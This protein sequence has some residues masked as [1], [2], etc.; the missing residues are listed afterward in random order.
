MMAS[1]H[2]FVPV[3]QDVQPVILILHILQG[4][5]ARAITDGVERITARNL[6]KS[7]MQVHGCQDRR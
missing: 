4:A 6:R 3:R 7:E 2:E 5:V 1:N